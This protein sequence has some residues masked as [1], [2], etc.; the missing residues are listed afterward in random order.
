[1]SVRVKYEDVAALETE[2]M[3]FWIMASCIEYRVL[4][5]GRRQLLVAP[6]PA[7]T[8]GSIMLPQF[9]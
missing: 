1:M 7:F 6:S 3:I 9:H 8:S 2:I 5:W 4:T